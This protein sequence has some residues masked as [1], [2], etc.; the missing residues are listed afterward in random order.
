MTSDKEK[1]SKNKYTILVTFYSSCVDNIFLSTAT[2]A[3]FEPCDGSCDSPASESLPR[4]MMT[5]AKGAENRT[6]SYLR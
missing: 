3:K 1:K 6:E 5:G 4:E 2:V